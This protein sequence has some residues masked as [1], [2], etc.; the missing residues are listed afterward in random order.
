MSKQN[1]QIFVLFDL[2]KKIGNGTFA[3][4]YEVNHISES[5]EFD[6]NDTNNIKHPQVLN[7]IK[8]KPEVSKKK[9]VVKVGRVTETESMI[10]C[11]LE[12]HDNIIDF[13]GINQPTIDIN[14]KVL[15]CEKLEF[16]CQ[17]IC[18]QLTNQN[19]V[20]YLIQIYNGLNYLHSK[21]KL[22]FCDL[23]L[24]NTG[25]GFDKKFKLFDLGS[26]K[27]INRKIQNPRDTNKLFCSPFF[28][29]ETVEPEP[30]DDIFSLWYIYLRQLGVRLPWEYCQFYQSAPAE[31]CDY[32]FGLYKMNFFPQLTI[33]QKSLWPFDFKHENFYIGVKWSTPQQKK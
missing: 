5:P 14:S 8:N 9:M 2:S 15:L 4:V 28:H 25:I 24:N 27:I 12:P 19:L 31:H 18:A 32:M 30:M 11:L 23:S 22:I 7:L 33:D 21:F 16:I 6:D 20:D 1:E 3:K 26:A 17:E 10:S 13:Y 29:A